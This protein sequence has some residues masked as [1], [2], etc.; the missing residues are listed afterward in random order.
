LDSPATF[1]SVARYGLAPYLRR[2]SERYGPLSSFRLGSQPIVFADDAALV[3][4]VLVTQQHLFTRDVGA[5]IARDLLGEGLLTTEDPPHLQRR[6]LMQPAFHRARVAS[7]ARAIAREAERACDLWDGVLALEIGTEMR[8]LTLAVVGETLFGSDMRGSAA[9]VVAVLERFLERG[10]SFGALLLA[11][12]PLLAALR[13]RAG[14]R[15]LFF[16]SERA[17]LERIIAPLV[18]RRRAGAGGD[19][20][21]SVLL[22]ARDEGGGGGLDDAALRSEVVTLVLAGHETTSNALTWTWLMLAHHP[23]VER[24]LHQELD[25]VLAGR[26]P[27]FE[28]VPQLRYTASVF[29]EAVRLFPPAPAFA[30]RPLVPVDLGG[31]RIPAGTS[32]YVSPY[33]TQRNPRYFEAPD[34]FRP[35]RWQGGP[36]PKFAYFPFGGGSKRCIGEPLAELEGVLVL[37]TIARRFS[38]RAASPLPRATMRGLTRPE[39]AVLLRPERRSRALRAATPGSPVEPA[40]FGSHV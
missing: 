3:E 40:S 4:Q 2:L 13:R 35:E 5:A 20:L 29:A 17:E 9:A 7:Y 8:K 36:P 32:I 10:N 16:R 19:D 23:E 26:V 33:V 15:S 37:A 30:R 18:E 27:S 6:R 12:A 34:D 11:V 24:R 14:R 21:L 28:D 1:A 39:G 38:L 31:Y 22:A 25:S